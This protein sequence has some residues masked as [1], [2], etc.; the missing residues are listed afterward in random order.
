[1]LAPKIHFLG[2]FDEKKKDFEGKG[3]FVNENEEI[4]F[5][6]DFKNGK[7]NGQGVFKFNNGDLYVGG[8]LND[9]MW[10][11]GVYYF[12]DNGSVVR[13][14]IFRGDEIKGRGKFSWVG[15]GRYEGDIEDGI[16][17]GRGEFF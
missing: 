13:G 1:M 2:E 8:F 6:G 5:Y 4:E 15:G 7:K 17:H 10:G 14:D 16:P 11:E 9:K 3:K 12:C